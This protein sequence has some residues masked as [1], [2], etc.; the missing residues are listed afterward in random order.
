[1]DPC[2]VTALIPSADQIKTG[3]S[4]IGSFVIVASVITSATPTP[5][6]GSRA[7][8]VYRYIEV[9]AL[10]FGRAKETGT[11]PATPKFDKSIEEAL[12]LIKGIAP[13]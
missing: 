10:L 13:S 3:L 5:V 11:L 6:A 8:R 2:S 9:A 1:M 7:A 4:V 12:R